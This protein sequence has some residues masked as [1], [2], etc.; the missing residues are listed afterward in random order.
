MGKIIFTSLF[1]VFFSHS[2]FAMDKEEAEVINRK[3]NKKIIN[4]NESIVKPSIK[5]SEEYFILGMKE[6]KDRRYDNALSY[7]EKAS[8][9]AIPKFE[10]YDAEYTV[11]SIY[12][13]MKFD[14][15]QAEHWYSL[16]ANHGDKE[17]VEAKKRVI[18]KNSSFLSYFY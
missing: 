17:A 7:L 5:P 13:F 6:L 16:A 11:G 15:K 3:N 8:E 4:T 1:C 12:E 18:D 14:Y 2:S 9:Y 10:N